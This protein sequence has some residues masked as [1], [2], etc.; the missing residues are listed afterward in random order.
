MGLQ[1][2]NVADAQV[3]A[4]GIETRNIVVAGYLPTRADGTPFVEKV[5]ERILEVVRREV[6]LAGVDQI[7]ISL[8]SGINV[9]VF[10]SYEMHNRIEPANG[11]AAGQ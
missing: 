5:D 11:V 3:K 1:N 6:P 9:G 10:K 4:G 2:V 7:F 8:R